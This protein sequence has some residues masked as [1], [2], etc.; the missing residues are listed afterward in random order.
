MTS[1]GPENTESEEYVSDLVI[2]RNLFKAVGK[3]G[4]QSR[5]GSKVTVRNNVLI[6]I[7]KPLSTGDPG[8]GRVRHLVRLEP[9]E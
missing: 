3:V 2:E 6:D 8:W 4:I 5:G 7:N 1:W 9:H